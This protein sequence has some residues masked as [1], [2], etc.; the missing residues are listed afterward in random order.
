MTRERVLEVLVS[1]DFSLMGKTFGGGFRISSGADVE[2]VIALCTSFRDRYQQYLEYL[3]M[4][5][6]SR[7]ELASKLRTAKITSLLKGLTPEEIAVI[8]GQI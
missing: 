4:V 2:D 7:G 8:K 3:N 5:L 1:N 6:E